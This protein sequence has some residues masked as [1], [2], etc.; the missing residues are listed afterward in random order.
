MNYFCI[1]YCI[2]SLN[3]DLVNNL[4][5][6]I[7]IGSSECH[8]DEDEWTEFERSAAERSGKNGANEYKYKE[9]ACWGVAQER[10]VRSMEGKK[11]RNIRKNVGKSE[12]NEKRDGKKKVKSVKR[13]GRKGWRTRGEEKRRNSHI[14]QIRRNEKF[15]PHRTKSVFRAVYSTVPS[16][17]M[18]QLHYV[19]ETTDTSFKSHLLAKSHSLTTCSH[20]GG[21]EKTF[22]NQMQISLPRKKTNNLVLK[23]S[24]FS[25]STATTIS[26]HFIRNIRPNK[27]NDKYLRMCIIVIGCVC[28]FPPRHPEISTLC[29]S[30]KT[31]EIDPKIWYHNCF[32][33]FLWHIVSLIISL[34][35]NFSY[36]HHWK[37]L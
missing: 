5:K 7:C 31:D 2:Y 37:P 25:T 17:W 27:W 10:N 6:N 30:A 1:V 18:I 23:R 32:P 34:F 22:P 11:G 15:F 19:E 28:F 3:F 9:K 35:P 4:F 36:I 20:I 33:V 26:T 13:E 16:D 8:K 12:E 21:T 24:L 29:C 14:E